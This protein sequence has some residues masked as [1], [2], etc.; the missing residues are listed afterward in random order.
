[1]INLK[2]DSGFHREI[3]F[4]LNHKIKSGVKHLLKKNPRYGGHFVEHYCEMMILRVG[5]ALFLGI[6][7][8]PIRRHG[9]Q[10]WLGVCRILM[11]QCVPYCSPATQLFLG[12]GCRLPSTCH[13]TQRGDIARKNCT[14]LATILEARPPTQS[15]RR[16]D[17]VIG[18][19]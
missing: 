18:Q 9:R 6:I 12:S 13:R 3:I 19:T 16:S 1:M 2:A 17:E 5:N 7:L 14:P 10:N 8:N 15:R 11:Y 4:L